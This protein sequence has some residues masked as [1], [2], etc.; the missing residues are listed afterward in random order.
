M[1]IPH[2]ITAL[3]IFANPVT[4][5]VLG[6][7]NVPVISMPAT[8][9]LASHA[10]PLN[11]RY[12]NTFVNDIFKDNILLTL[13]YLNGDVTKKEDINWKKIEDNFHYEFSLNPG[14]RFV[15]HD[16]ISP[17][18]KDNVVKTTHAY[19]N[20]TDGFKSD[21]YL[22]GDGVCHIASLIH[23][24]AKDAG[25]ESIAPSNH[26]FAVI[27]DIPKKYG[28]AIYADPGKNSIGE[29]QNLYIKNT[30]AKPVKFVFDYKDNVLT[31]DIVSLL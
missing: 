16:K 30:F 4:P 11:D 27:P 21:G 8:K 6:A 15:F 19:F 7:S 23:W 12:G 5:E 2:L 13:H 22:T 24:V 20:F 1:L 10:M 9:T 17:G 3:I 29:M 31:L 25:L 26:D 18:Y 28:V 14:E